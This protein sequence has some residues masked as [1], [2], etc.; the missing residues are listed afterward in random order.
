MCEGSGS[1]RREYFPKNTSVKF[2]GTR[3][4]Y[5][6]VMRVLVTLTNFN[7]K[8]NGLSLEDQVI[9]SWRN[10]SLIWIIHLDA[11]DSLT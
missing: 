11:E 1:E 3:S 5:L 6:H 8:M 2:T 9:T 10:G 4:S 7:A